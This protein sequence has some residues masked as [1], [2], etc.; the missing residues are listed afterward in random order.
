MKAFNYCKQIL[1]PIVYQ[2]NVNIN[3]TVVKN[4]HV[5]RT[6]KIK[7]KIV[8]IGLLHLYLSGGKIAKTYVKSYLAP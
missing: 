1:F 5:F 6:I 3:F 8:V 7:I 4:A 2:F